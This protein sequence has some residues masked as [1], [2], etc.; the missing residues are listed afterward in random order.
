MPMPPLLIDLDDTLVSEQPVSEETFLAVARV[1]A[2][3]HEVDPAAL[4]VS[5]R[6]SA[7]T[8]WRA[9]PTHPFAD[10]IGISSWE[11]LWCRFEGDGPDL[12]ALRAWAPTYRRQAWADALAQYGIHDPPLATELGERYGVE[13]RARHHTHADSA[14]A[15]RELG[16]THPLAL[17]TNGASDLQR[18]KLTASGL[19]AFF[20]VVVVSGDVGVGKPDPAVFHAVTE[21]LGAD[22]A[23]MIGDSLPRDITGALAAGLQAIWVNRDGAPGAPPS[24][25]PVITTLAELPRALGELA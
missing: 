17:L 10:R 18:E 20:E 4:A 15:L 14:P 25:V 3:R 8:L 7:R 21:R 24:G 22:G 13:R 6:A 19:Q 9:A 11:A 2:E 5:A 1:A 16:A 12:A 23:V